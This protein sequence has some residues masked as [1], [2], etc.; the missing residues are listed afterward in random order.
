MDVHVFMLHIPNVCRQQTLHGRPCMGLQYVRGAVDIGIDVARS[1]RSLSPFHIDALVDLRMQ[2]DVRCDIFRLET[3]GVSG[4]TMSENVSFP[5]S[6]ISRPSL[7]YA[8]KPAWTLFVYGLGNV[9]QCIELDFLPTSFSD[10][11]E[12]GGRWPRVF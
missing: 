4:A 5:F 3:T 7:F 8:G 12:D 9:D 1:M 11:L 2:M 6:D 10:A